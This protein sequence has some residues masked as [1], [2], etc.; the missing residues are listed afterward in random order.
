MIE[1]D[2]MLPS[3]PSSSNMDGLR[4]ERIPLIWNAGSNA[5]RAFL[6]FFAAAIRNPNTRQAYHRAASKF[7]EWAELNGLRTL[8]EIEPL[9]VAAWVELSGH[10]YS[11]ATAVSPLMV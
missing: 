1:I 5:Q 11:P 4:I 3:N 10:T 8:K 6:E 9:H 2:A 7:L